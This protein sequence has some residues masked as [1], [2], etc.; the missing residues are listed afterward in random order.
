M[1]WRVTIA[2]WRRETRWS[3]EHEASRRRHAREAAARAAD[4]NWR[5]A[6]LS[7]LEY[8]ESSTIGLIFWGHVNLGG[9]VRTYRLHTLVHGPALTCTSQ[10]VNKGLRAPFNSVKILAISMTFS[11]KKD[12]ATVMN[13]LKCFSFL[14]TL[15]I[16]VIRLSALMD[17]YIHSLYVLVIKILSSIPKSSAPIHPLYHP[18]SIV[19]PTCHFI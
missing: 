5:S 6:A 8:I 14:E 10:K 18:L 15:H 7:S 16:Q 19:G 11:S 12:M 3:D 17:L 13:L 2:G 9:P 4:S 1:N